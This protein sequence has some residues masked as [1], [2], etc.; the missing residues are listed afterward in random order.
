MPAKNVDEPGNRLEYLA[1][2]AV[3]LARTARRNRK[4]LAGQNNYAHKLVELR[5]EATNTFSELSAGSAG[6]VAATAELLDLIFGTGASPKERGKAVNDLIY[7][8]RTTWRQTAHQTTDTVEACYL[9]L[10]ILAGT[11]RG[12]LLTI[13]KQVNCCFTATC[14]DACLVMLRR[15]VEIAIIEAF[16]HRKIEATV[17]DRD[18]N[19]FFLR[20][21]IRHALNQTAWA[22]SRNTKRHLPALKELGDS[23]AHGRYFHATKTDVE[24]VRLPARVVVEEFLR[25][26]NLL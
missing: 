15:L 4:T 5:A 24:N 14:Y 11:K 9:P 23:S 19:Y 8:L 17:K 25:H 20:D 22:L 1:K 13:G 12:Y 16:E 2:S 26:A 21:L 6:D 3:K 7:S 18:G 10:E